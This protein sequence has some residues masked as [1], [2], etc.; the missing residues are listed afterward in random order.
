MYW[1]L[2]QSLGASHELNS[3]VGKLRKLDQVYCAWLIKWVVKREIIQLAELCLTRRWILSGTWWFWVIIWQYWL[4]LGQYKLVLLDIRWYMVSKGLVCLYILGKVEIW[5]GDTDAWHTHSQTEKK[6]TQLVSSIKHKLSH[7]TYCHIPFKIFD[8]W[9]HIK[10]TEFS[11][12]G[13]CIQRSGDHCTHLPHSTQ[14]IWFHNFF[15]KYI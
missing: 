9:K 8:S 10:W 4:V 7:A 1:H 6:A 11:N 13:R 15:G 5:S 12:W 2:A 3:K 14:D